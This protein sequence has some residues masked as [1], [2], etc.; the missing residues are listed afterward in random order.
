MLQMYEELG[1]TADRVILR[2]P[3]TWNGIQAS[4]RLEAE[5]H[6]THLILVYSVVQGLAAA[7]AGCSVVQPNVG[8]IAD[9]YTKHPNFI[10]DPSGPREDSGFT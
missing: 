5:G 6:A 1:V 9:W 7:Q 8:R 3:A 2:I 4:A 10:K